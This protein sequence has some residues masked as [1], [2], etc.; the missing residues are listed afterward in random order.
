MNKYDLSILIPARNEEFLSR[1]VLE[2]LDKK[3]GKT[4]I[5]VGLDGEWADPGIPDHPDV[6]ILYY[7]KSIGQRAMTNQLCRISQS[8][9]VMKLDAHVA[10]DEGFDVKMMEDMQDDWT[11]V[12]TMYNLWAFD[13][14]CKECGHRVFQ[15]PIPTCCEKCGSEVERFYIWKP[16]PNRPTNTSYCFDYEPHFQYFSKYKK[17]QIG[18]LVETMS[19]QGSC[20]MVTRERYWKQNICDEELGSWGSQGIEV[21]CKTWLS[22]GKVIVTKKTWY[23]HLFRTGDF[24][25]PYPTPTES[26]RLAKEK[27]RNLFFENRWPQQVYPLSWLI[28]KF[29]PIEGQTK[30]GRPFWTDQDLEMIKRFDSKVIKK[31]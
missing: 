17:R 16:N 1:T 22:G 4:E 14:K 11:L 12:P 13:W 24:H 15:N 10:L 31:Q 30:E 26:M 27:T 8:K 20:F 18:D 23:A 6:T 5:L 21:A 9:Y 2:I 29:W 7:P 25:F 3:K 28:E 19:I